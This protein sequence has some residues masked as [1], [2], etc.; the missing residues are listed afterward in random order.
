MVT[1]AQTLD[2]MFARLP[3]YQRVGAAAYKENLDNIELLMEHLGQ[4][5]Q[6]FK[7]IHVAGTNGKGS[8][9][10]MLA[11]ILQEAGYRV[12]L[13]T[14]PH[15]KDFRERI[16]INGQPIPEEKVMAF[17]QEQRS[18]IEAHGFSFFELTVAMAFDFFA[19]E[20]VDFAVIEVGLG[21]RLDATNIIRPELAVITNIGLDHLQFLGNTLQ[22]IAQEKAGII[23]EYIPVVIGERQAET[24]EVFIAFAKAKQAPIHFAE[25]R[26]REEL[27][28]D[29]RGLYQKKNQRTARSSIAVLRSLGHAVD[30]EAVVRGLKSVVANTGLLG[31][32]Q[33]LNEQPLTITDTAHNVAGLSLVLE[34]LEHQEFDQL[35]IVLG[36]VNDKDLSSILPLFP[37]TAHYYFC[38]PNVPRGLEADLLQKKA[39]LYQLAGN[40]YV[41]VAEAYRAAQEQAGL[42]DL[43]FIGG[44]TFTVA[45]VV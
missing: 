5:Q 25:D 16:K 32:W 2:W 36:M 39:K 37:K 45:E 43:I 38:K 15:L 20:N 22:A 18:F 7:S 29:L 17:V 21:G 8:T 35:H 28:T 41:S 3:M 44:S 10:H 27:D 11:S 6:D 14:S 33:Q 4:P 9:S 40:A 42:G 23:K 19:K 26:E 13:Y 1:Y 24:T 12:G 31:R 30:E 34:Q